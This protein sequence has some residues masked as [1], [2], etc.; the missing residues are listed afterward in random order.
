MTWYRK[1]SQTKWI[2]HSAPHATKSTVSVF[3]LYQELIFQLRYF[4]STLFF[5]I[6]S[7]NFVKYCLYLWKPTAL[8]DL[9]NFGQ[10]FNRTVW[11]PGRERKVSIR[12]IKKKDWVHRACTQSSE[13][14]YHKISPLKK[15][16]TSFYTEGFYSKHLNFHNSRL[17]WVWSF[18][19]SSL[20]SILFL[21]KKNGWE[22]C[23][24]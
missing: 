16:W 11:N 21:K 7:Q 17:W 18:F 1:Q 6:S 9:S 13:T 2:L 19:P 22:S 14:F 20:R 10:A 4:N 23:P 15:K 5:R 24:N 8:S 3:N 12:E